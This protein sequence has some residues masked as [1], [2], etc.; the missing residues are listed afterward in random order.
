VIANTAVNFFSVITLALVGWIVTIVTDEGFEPENWSAIRWW[1]AG[2]YVSLGLVAS[3]GQAISARRA[4]AAFEIACGKLLKDE[5][6]DRQRVIERL[7]TPYQSTLILS[8]IALTTVAVAL[9][10]VLGLG[11]GTG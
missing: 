4:N 6:C 1:L 3:L 11:G 5:G 10:V 2:L 8:G 7:T 9:A